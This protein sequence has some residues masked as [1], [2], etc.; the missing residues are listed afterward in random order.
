VW[1]VDFTINGKRY[2]RSTKTSDHKIARQVLGEIQ[3]QIARGR[4]NL[5]NTNKKNTLL[6][7]FIH[8]YLNEGTTH[9]A[10]ATVAQEK[11]Y[12]KKLLRLVGDRV[13]RTITN[14]V[15]NKWKNA[16]LESVNETTFNTER[17]ELHAIFN[18]AKKWGYID[19]NPFASIEKAKPQERR[20][21][22]NDQ[23]IRRL[24]KALNENIAKAKNKKRRHIHEL[25]KMFV[26]F[27]LCTG[28]R[29]GEALGLAPDDI[30]WEKGVIYLNK[31]KD[32]EM[33]II[34]L[35]KKAKEVLVALGNNMFKDLNASRVT[36]KFIDVAEQAG[37]GEFKL[38]S[39]RHTFACRL[40]A[41]GVDIY[42]VS[43][44]LGHSDLKTTM[45]YAKVE[46]GTL[47]NAVDKL[48]GL[49]ETDFPATSDVKVLPA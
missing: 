29:R 13:L 47:Q 32:R 21:F 5:T 30:N 38:H 7:K 46:L 12:L 33:R 42:T 6:S 14:V 34:P 39:L 35:N 4:F 11:H 44:L 8:K 45:I 23:E 37:L 9:K 49:D 2:I 18:V 20:L 36:H 10:D 25:F 48:Q 31:T 24:F 40:I 16:L 15:L 22:M 17:R 3:G 41:S 19:E 28:L 27:L 43:K 26:E 1:D